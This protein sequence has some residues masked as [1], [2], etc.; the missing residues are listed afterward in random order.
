MYP[1]RAAPAGSPPP[2]AAAP[3]PAA[4]VPPDLLA[5]CALMALAGLLTLWPVVT[6]VPDLLEIVFSSDSFSRAFG[7]L[8]LTFWLMLAFFGCA[9]LLLAFRLT[10][11]D[12]VAR[13][14]TYVLLGGLALSILVGN[15][16][17]TGLWITM[18]VS[19]AA[20]AVLALA[21]GPRAF[22]AQGAQGE[23]PD[24][25]V[26]AR[27]LIAVWAGIM[28]VAGLMMLPTGSLAAKYAIVG[29]LFLALGAV[30]FFLNSRLA[31]GDPVARVVVSTGAVVY[32]VLLLI[33]GDRSPG[34]LLPL[35]M[36]IGVAGYLWIPADV[37]RYFTARA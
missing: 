18:L 31:H 25:L 37:Q 27:T 22:F 16:K 26:I 8:L 36:V 28:A 17:T 4:G 20:V 24:G 33:L 2:R 11:G 9:C 30:A 35:A 5:V 32:L 21:P 34:L 14:L 10:Q 19:A 29:L 1:P 12:R 3:R 15:T 6:S 7:L 13:G 23:H